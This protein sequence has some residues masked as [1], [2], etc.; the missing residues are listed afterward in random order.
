MHS[1]MPCRDFLD[2]SSCAP[3]PLLRRERPLVNASRTEPL[4][5]PFLDPARFDAVWRN[6]LV[7]ARAEVGR[8]ADFPGELGLLHLQAE[9]ARVSGVICACHFSS[10][11]VSGS[12]RRLA[13]SR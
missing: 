1:C 2:T 6:R 8:Q 7:G 10:R 13:A 9:M 5:A 4:L 3:G 11:K 12:S